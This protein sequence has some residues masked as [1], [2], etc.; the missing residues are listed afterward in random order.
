MN[1]N[2]L[3]QQLEF[4]SAAEAERRSTLPGSPDLHAVVHPSLGPW[5]K[6]RSTLS[7]RYG[8]AW[9]EIG[10]SLLMIV[11]GYAAHVAITVHFGNRTGFIAAIPA[12]VWIGFW[13]HSLLNFG[14]EA[15]HYNLSRDRRRNDLLSDWTIWL[16]FPQSTKTYRRSHWQHHLHLGDL[17]DT[18]VSYHNCLSPW[19]FTRLVTGLYLAELA[20]RYL[21]GR[22]GTRRTARPA[23]APSSRVD[24]SLAVPILR[25]LTVHSIFIGIALSLA[26]YATAAA[27]AV[28]V[29][30][31]FPAFASLR[32]I[33]EHRAATASCSTDFRTV[34]HGAV[35]RNFDAGLFSHFFGAAGFNRHLLHH[36]DPTVSYTRFDEMAAF[37]DSTALA[38]ELRTAQSTYLG[39]FLALLRQSLRDENRSAK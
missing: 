25:A 6:F 26:C 35:N 19:F 20:G 7:P 29:M 8:V 34:Q 2:S 4:P 9:R 28:A 16:F 1:S 14:H 37:F 5:L 39:T 32:Q 11:G 13:L 27:W 10:L 31:V 17:E 15:A 22:S 24:E 30:L 38:D 36:W 18:E 3:A 21:L 33:L 23:T 12:A